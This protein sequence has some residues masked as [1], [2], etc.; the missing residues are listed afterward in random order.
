MTNGNAM[1]VQKRWAQWYRAG[2]VM[3]VYSWEDFPE[4]SH[5][6]CRCKHEVRN[7]TSQADALLSGFRAGRATRNYTQK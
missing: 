4:D 7:H 6:D 2:Y 3:G 1:K 5:N